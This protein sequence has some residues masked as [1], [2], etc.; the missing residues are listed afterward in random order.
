M[1]RKPVS[2]P[3]HHFVIMPKLLALQ[4]EWETEDTSWNM[5]LSGMDKN[6]RMAQWEQR[7]L[8]RKEGKLQKV[9]CQLNTYR[10]EED[11][12]HT[13]SDE[14]QPCPSSNNL[15]IW[16]CMGREREWKNRYGTREIIKCLP[17]IVETRKE[18]KRISTGIIYSVC[19]ISM[20]FR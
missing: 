19:P 10:M 9:F 6:V 7:M 5:K 3:W 4:E 11:L 8:G 15:K 20:K 17:A 14:D 2:A 1:M 16:D 18:C 13:L 12:G